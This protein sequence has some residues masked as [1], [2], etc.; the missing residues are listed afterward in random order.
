ML[1][2]N[3]PYASHL[4]VYILYEVMITLNTLHACTIV[5]SMA[6]MHI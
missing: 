6:V 3:K 5:G 1:G 2:H 4:S